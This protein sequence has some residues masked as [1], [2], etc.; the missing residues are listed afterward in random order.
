[1]TPYF[2][3]VFTSFIVITVISVVPFCVF[4]TTK[5]HV[6]V[7]VFNCVLGIVRK[8]LKTRCFA[9]PKSPTLYQFHTRLFEKD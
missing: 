2:T 1:M 9:S 4:H 8:V 7:T 6:I 3:T 5:T